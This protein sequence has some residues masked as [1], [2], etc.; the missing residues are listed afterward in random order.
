MVDSHSYHVISEYTIE[1]QIIERYHPVERVNL[2]RLQ[3]PVDHAT[4][5]LREFDESI[6]I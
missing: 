5:L 2:M 1:T 4:R 6:L 3:L